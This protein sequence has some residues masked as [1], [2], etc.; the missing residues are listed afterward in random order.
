MKTLLLLILAMLISSIFFISQASA[1]SA[2]ASSIYPQDKSTV[3]VLREDLPDYVFEYDLE[4]LYPSTWEFYKKLDIINRDK[5]YSYYLY[6][7]AI[8]N[9]RHK[10]VTLALGKGKGKTT[11]IPASIGQ[12]LASNISLEPALGSSKSTL[13]SSFSSGIHGITNGPTISAVNFNTDSHQ[14]V[15]TLLKNN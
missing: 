9:V 2:S 4:R 12:V 14:T 11:P 1:K 10:I 8:T 7:P 15:Y 5:V 6:H 13:G 3:T